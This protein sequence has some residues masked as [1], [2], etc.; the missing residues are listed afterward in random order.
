MVFL[1]GEGL[2]IIFEIGNIVYDGDICCCVV[3]VKNKRMI[4]ENKDL[5]YVRYGM[6]KGFFMWL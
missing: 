6:G 3:I 5:V 2:E 4:K 1:W